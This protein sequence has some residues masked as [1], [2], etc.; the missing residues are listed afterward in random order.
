MTPGAT[1]APQL[2]ANAYVGLFA[3]LTVAGG[4]AVRDLLLGFP[5]RNAAPT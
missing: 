3:G 1:S 4:A 5:R 2:T